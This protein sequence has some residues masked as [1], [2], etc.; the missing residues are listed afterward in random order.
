MWH[1]ISS[2]AIVSQMTLTEYRGEAAKAT[3]LDEYLKFLNDAQSSI[4]AEWMFSVVKNYD[5]Q[6]LTSAQGLN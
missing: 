3:P 6:P 5:S 4:L 1:N 2:H